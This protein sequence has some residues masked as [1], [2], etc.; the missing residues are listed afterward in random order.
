[1]KFWL[2]KRKVRKEK[3]TIIE[4]NQ[5]PREVIENIGK[6]V[7]I[8]KECSIYKDSVEIGDYTYINGGKIFYAKIGKFCSVGYNVVLGS[9][10]HKLNTVTTYP[11]R[12]RVCADSRPLIDFPVQEDCIVG[13]GVWIGN[14]VHIM[15]G[16]Q[17]GNGAVIGSNAVVTHDVAPY[18]VVAGV[19]AREIKKLW[20]ERT[21]EYLESLEWWNWEIDKIK[22]AV[23][24]DAFESIENMKYYIENNDHS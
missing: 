15:Q 14:D 23:E 13:N 7:N 1:M 22:H 4:T 21:I 9:G 10:R 3:N 17:I 20:D 6:C 8:N 2:L 18:T 12:A 5:I 16:V 19:P 11:L 24:C